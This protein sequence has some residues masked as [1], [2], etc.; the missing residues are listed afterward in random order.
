LASPDS[1][2]FSE[3]DIDFDHEYD[4]NTALSFLGG[5]FFDLESDGQKEFIITG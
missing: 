1:P 4:K 5:T 3:I 2:S